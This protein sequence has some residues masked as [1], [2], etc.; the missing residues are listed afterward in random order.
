MNEIKISHCAK[1]VIVAVCVALLSVSC[2][3]LENDMSYPTIL[4]LDNVIS[5]EFS[6]ELKAKTEYLPYDNRTFQSG[7]FYVVAR[8]AASAD[9]A[10]KILKNRDFTNPIVHNISCVP[11]KRDGFSIN[12]YNLGP[13]TQI[14]YCAYLATSDKTL[15]GNVRSYTT[16]DTMAEYVVRTDSATNI[17]FESA[18]LTGSF[19]FNILQLG[20]KVECVFLV[21]TKKDFSDVSIYY[22]DRKGDTF[23][24]DIDNLLPNTTYYYVACLKTTSFI[25]SEMDTETYFSGQ[26]KSFITTLSDISFESNADIVGFKEARLSCRITG[27]SGYYN[28]GF[29]FSDTKSQFNASN[30]YSD[31]VKCASSLRNL[32]EET[33]FDEYV[34]FMKTT[35]YYYAPFINLGNGVYLFGEVRSVAFSSDM[36]VT[37]IGAEKSGNGKMCMSGS[38]QGV[39]GLCDVKFFCSNTKSSFTQDDEYDPD[40]LRTFESSEGGEFSMCISH[41]EQGTTYY[42]VAIAQYGDTCLFGEVKQFVMP[43]TNNIIDVETNKITAHS[44]QLSFTYDDVNDYYYHVGFLVSPDNSEPM[45]NDYNSS[46]TIYECSEFV[47]ENIERETFTMAVSGL[48]P[49]TQYYYRPFMSYDGGCIYG[50]TKTFTTGDVVT[51]DGAVDMG[52]DILWA[53]D[54]MGATADNRTGDYYAWGEV[55]PKTTF[56]LDNY[57]FSSYESY[58]SIGGTDH[59]AAT[60]HLGSGWRMPTADEILQLCKLCT[61]TDCVRDSVAG[62]LYTSNLTGNEIFIPSLNGDVGFFACFWSCE[63]DAGKTECYVFSPHSSY[64]EIELNSYLGLPIRPVY[65]PYQ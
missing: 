4:T 63:K 40:V 60:V 50:A 59:D 28:V 19:N 24:Y 43:E 9:E 39:N 16:S 15:I 32:D 44:A 65:D 34:S 45:Y 55:T 48:S 46:G 11:K 49:N 10:E 31:D 2:D 62:Y 58:T 13:N 17:G 27:I 23:S 14:F 64:T 52:M 57:T 36:A 12:V 30:M 33:F 37:T 35:R 22:A 38:L 56:T 25:G 61:Y 26:V 29:V 47:F 42:Y 54:N 51:V 3:T 6:I 21:S 5:D 53:T 8:D 41:L 1:K 7:F 18:R 20:N